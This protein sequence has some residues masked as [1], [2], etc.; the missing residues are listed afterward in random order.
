MRETEGESPE[1]VIGGSG[2]SPRGY[3]SDLSESAQTLL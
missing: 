1:L 3:R 2:G